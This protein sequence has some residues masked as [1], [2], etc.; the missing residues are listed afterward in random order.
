MCERSSKLRTKNYCKKTSQQNTTKTKKTPASHPAPA[1]ISLLPVSH[2]PSK[3]LPCK[4]H[5]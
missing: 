5:S 2:T 3:K 4:M 1:K